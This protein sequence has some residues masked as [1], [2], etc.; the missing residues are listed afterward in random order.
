MAEGF[1]TGNAVLG[2]RIVRVIVSA[3]V[4]SGAR[5]DDRDDEEQG[6][7]RS[8]VKDPSLQSHMMM[9]QNRT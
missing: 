7:R 3:S 9:R 5:S 6:N 1:S 8:I 2:V 4:I